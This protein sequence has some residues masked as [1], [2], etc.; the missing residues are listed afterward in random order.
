MFG[1]CLL[2]PTIAAEYG[3]SLPAWAEV[4]TPTEPRPARLVSFRL[5]ADEHSALALALEIPHCLV[6]LDDSAG[7]LAATRLGI[8]F[9]G[10]VELLGL[11]HWFAR[12]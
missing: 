11:F 3:E 1:R 12:C 2:T 4:L 6:A 7:R 10:T 5:D 9:T 8:D